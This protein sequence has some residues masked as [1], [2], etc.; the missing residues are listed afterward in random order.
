M[1]RRA[2]RAGVLALSVVGIWAWAGGRMLAQG[3]GP[4][5][6]SLLGGAVGRRPMTFADLQRM[7]RVSDPQVSPSGRWVMF[8]ATD[9]DLEKN[10]KVN[11]LWVVPMAAAPAD[12][13]GKA[14][15]SAALRNDKQKSGADGQPKSGADG[16]VKGRT[17]RQV[18]FWKDGESGGRFSPDGRQ[19][20]FVAT[21]SATGLS[22]IFLA[23]W[24]DAAGTLGTPKRLTNV[25][26]E[27]DGAVWSPDS[28]R[29]LFASRVYPE[30]S[31]EAA[32]L[33]EDLCNKKKD[34]AAAANP[35]KAQVFEHLLYRHW[36]SYVG[37]K[38]SHVLVVSATDGNAVRDLTPRRDI[39][40]AESPTF[41]LGGPVGYAW[42]PGSEEIAYVTNVD[43]VPA[44]STNN[45]VFTLLLDD[46]GARPRKVSTS[47]GSDDAPAYS[48]DGKY[49][50][51]RS[52]ARATYESD[53]F[54]LM[55]FDRLAGTTKELLPKMDRWVD[56]F[57]WNPVN[58]EICFTTAD[59][60]GERI[61]CTYPNVGDSLFALQGSG[62]Y[63]ELQFAALKDVGYELVATKMTV[64]SPSV[65]V[66]LFR[67]DVKEFADREIASVSSQIVTTEVRLTHLNDDLEQHLDLPK[68]TSFTFSGA[69]G[70]PVQGFMIPPPK[71]DA[72]RKYPVKFL[73]HGGPQ[74][75]W[76]DA[77][78]YRWNAELMAASGYVVVMVNPRGSTGYGQA[79]IDGVNGDW[80]GK[81]YVD[82]M[83]GLDFA[84]SKFA[85]ID[86]T[87]ECALG[88]SYGG[89]MANWI[90]THTDRF[91]CIVTHDGMFNPASAYG[92]TEEIWFNEWEF[93]RTGEVAPGQPWR[94][95]AGPIASDPFRKWSP[96]LSIENAKTPTLV[97]HSQRDYR[98]DVSEGF[99]LFTALQRQ[100]VPSKMLYFPDE[101]HWV[102]KPQNSKLWYETVGD[103]CDKWTKTNLYAPVAAPAKGG[104]KGKGVVRVAVPVVSAAPLV[105]AAPV[106]ADAA[107]EADLPQR[108]VI[109]E[110][111]TVAIGA[112][113]DE[114]KLGSDAKVTIALRNVSDHQVAFAHRPGA[115]NPEFSYRIEVKDA[116][117]HAV[118]LTAYGREAL[119]HQQEETRMVEYVQPGKAAVQTAHLEKLVNMN[120]PGRYTVVVFRKDAK[121]GA[122][123]RSNE[124][125]MNVVP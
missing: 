105:A 97:V 76:G 60:G 18:T 46:A 19:V 120:R 96:M 104:A 93:R 37:P 79:F 51:F 21:D 72:A 108:A 34:D 20:A 78:S 77:W 101:G 10:T 25:S 41:T 84:E 88:A 1:K 11:H 117:G 36:N 44:A 4:D 6:D 116:K 87:R 112:P 45:D 5:S 35:V 24:D 61:F 115:N 109:V 65:V 56:E 8:S 121:S 59:H 29:I 106:D 100:N 95:A 22:Q 31:D 2:I 125:T 123:V 64:E 14:D 53:R 16:P 90:L 107:S 9:V 75:A 7:K 15:S 118:A 33:N 114:V 119:L 98:L 12:G 55:L 71:F 62:E 66:A 74:G 32:W 30:C 81:A 43:L 38:R 68:M 99:Q 26:T 113:Q 83:K 13:A 17:E 58:P 40:D 89:F 50:A 110:D 48:P 63:G 3:F 23:T 103:W 54:R 27:A 111:F 92:T 70:A 94:Y 82:L 67:G 124:L 47:M 85:F 28:K 39:G 52:Q 91:A 69:E 42:A 86:K 49:L 57:V 122:V 80:G 102:L 73:I